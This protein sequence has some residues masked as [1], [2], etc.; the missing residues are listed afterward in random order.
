MGLYY[1][2]INLSYVLTERVE[3]ESTRDPSGTD[4]LYTTFRIT[5]R[6]VVSPNTD[7][8]SGA[9]SPGATMARVRHMLLQPRQTLTYQTPDGVSMVSAGPGND[10]ANGP[11]PLHCSIS[12]VT[13]GS[14]L[15][16]YAV[17]CRLTDCAA[18]DDRDYLSLRWTESVSI[19]EQWRTVKTRSGVMIVKTGIDADALRLKITPGVP[20]GFRRESARYEL[21]DNNL[22]IRFTFVDREMMRPPPAPAIRCRGRQVE[23]TP[24]WHGG[25]L[26]H[27]EIT[28]QLE[29]PKGVNPR[30]LLNAGIRIVMSRV[31][32][33]RAVRSNKSGIA[34]VQTSFA[35][36]LDDDQN[37]V[38]IQARWKMA[39][40]PQRQAGKGQSDAQMQTLPETYL[41]A[42]GNGNLP[43]FPPPPPPQP[44]AQGRETA[45][46]PI[47]IASWMGAKL[48]GSDPHRAIGGLTRG[49]APD[50]RLIAAAL[51]DPCGQTAT[52]SQIESN[53]WAG[54]SSD[55]AVVQ[56]VDT[57][58]PGYGPPGYPGYSDDQAA[59][60]AANEPTPGVWDVY[61]LT[62][63]YKDSGGN[64]VCPSTKQGEKAAEIQVCNTLLTMRL[65]WT[66][67]RTGG[68]PTYPQVKPPDTSNV[69]Y[70][71]GAITAENVDV[72]GD[73]VSL[74]YSAS[75]IYEYA[76]LDPTAVSLAAP[77]P[78]FLQL[79]PAANEP[80][81]I[82]GT[83]R[84]PFEGQGGANPFTGSGVST[85]GSPGPGG[86]GP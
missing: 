68:P 19:D 74:I 8:A 22:Q 39:P 28:L 45:A 48:P 18:A 15:V 36:S 11:F 16:D 1:N 79:G 67:R 43:V 26:R 27:G 58:G 2:G 21:S 49:T 6:A 60:Y 52:I 64:A 14:F 46:L 47:G 32:A 44:N 75:G 34:L 3:Q 81:T 57:A 50:I 82:F 85:G 7:P 33:T 62:A 70:I 30:E 35:E 40:E 9:E 83:A 63:I 24:A 86:V 41:D 12:Q 84:W 53:V 38:E 59:L 4:Q 5:V 17:E 65:E 23:S 73:G 66:V 76:F 78:P 25:G 72:A 37:R 54:I 31:N 10:A 13:Q 56:V 55:G 77:V 29:G 61:Q 69:R 42:T 51:N 71:G 80:N 20:Q